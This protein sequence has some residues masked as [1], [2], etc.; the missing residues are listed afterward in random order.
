MSSS[1]A[2]AARSARL[3]ELAGAAGHPR[4]PTGLVDADFSDFGSLSFG[5]RNLRR[6]LPKDVYR[7]F[8]KSL[9]TGQGVDP[10]IADIIANAMKTWA[11]S[12]GAT[13]FTHW[14]QPITVAHQAE[15]HDAFLNIFPGMDAP[16]LD[17]TGAELIRGEPDGSSFPSGGL[18]ETHEARGYTFWDPMSP[19]FI[20][21]HD[22]GNKTL[23]IPTAFCSWTGE[24]LDQKTPILR[25]TESLSQEAVKLL[26]LE[27]DKR[28]D[29][30]Y[31]TLGCEQEFFLID[32]AFALQ[33][34]DLILAGRTVLGAAPSKGQELDDHYFAQ[35][36]TRVMACIQEVESELWKLGIPAKTRHNEVAPSQYEMAPIFEAASVASDHNLLMMD[37][38]DRMARRHDLHFLVHEKPFAGVNGSGKHNNW[39]MSTNRGENLLEPGRTPEHNARFLLFLAATI[40]GVDDHQDLMRASMANIGQEHRLGANEAPPAIISVYLGEE[41]D[42]VCREIIAPDVSAGDRRMSKMEIGVNA[43]PAL[44]RDRTDRNRT[45][46]FAFTGNKFEFRAVGSTQHVGVPNYVMNTVAADG[47]RAVREAIEKTMES[48]VDYKIARQKVIQET[49]KNH[50][51]VVF[52]GNGYSK[53]WPVEAEKRGL[54]NIPSTAEAVMQFVNQKNIDLFVKYN[55]LKE[56]EIKARCNIM[57]EQYAMGVNIE[58]KVTAE[59]AK[60]H[61]LP[62]AI[63]HQTTLAAAIVAVKSAGVDAP[64]AQVAEL[65][66]ASGNVG[67][68]LEK[69]EALNKHLEGQSAAEEKGELEWARYMRDNVL[70]AMAEVRT[71]SDA[72]ELAVDD[73]TWSLPK[74]REMLFIK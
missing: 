61:V 6:T 69:T 11:M 64:A 36:P 54:L 21:E 19:A 48:G 68:L 62:A 37:V 41:L 66:A 53:E 67:T 51:R 65:Q 29:H 70:P 20:R 55:V 16:M 15:K 22:N 52:N 23:C 24:A 30:V 10:K 25:S 32:R 34:P 13:H 8:K 17:L 4:Q 73:E 12:H 57:L 38:L 26:R 31:T 40:K 71:V 33:R 1:T 46:P 39:S 63:K 44:R 50:Y 27:G 42:Q 45:S 47:I 28:T 7:A 72:I 14:F 59:L 2:S 49:L 43:M 74:Y 5:E 9:A 35:M 18:R 60:S 56:S 3:A 58:G